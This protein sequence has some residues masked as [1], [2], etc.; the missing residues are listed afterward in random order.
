[1]NQSCH[2][3]CVYNGVCTSSIVLAQQ[4]ETIRNRLPGMMGR[5]VTVG[6][7]CANFTGY[8]DFLSN[9]RS[10][11]E[12]GALVRLGN[13]FF[14][15]EA[16]RRAIDFVTRMWWVVL[17]VAVV[18]LVIMF[19]VVILFHC[20]LPRPEHAK[21]RDERRRTKRRNRQVAAGG[22]EG[23]NYNQFEQGN[24]PQNYPQYYK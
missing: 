8:C 10:A 20:I 13:L 11:D 12:N 9:C 3:C 5:N 1:M 18:I 16:F 21:N 24:Y 15:S 2:V 19:A 6:S 4:N 22:G 23:A 17:I 7:P 14:N